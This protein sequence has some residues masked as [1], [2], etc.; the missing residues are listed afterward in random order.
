M[1]A[2]VMGGGL[3]RSASMQTAL[4]GLQS[5]IA[6]A[7]GVLIR[8]EAG[9]G[10]QEFARAVHLAVDGG[11]P[12]SVECLIEDAMRGRSSERPFIIVD[13]SA[14]A[15]LERDLFGITGTA[16]GQQFDALDRISDK[17]CL[18]AA[19]DG[20]IVFRHLTE[21]PARLQTRLA[22]ILRDGEALVETE[23]GD[24]VVRP[25]TT[26]PVATIELTADEDR[27]LPDLR[28]RLGRTTIDV[29]VLRNRREDIPA[30]VRFFLAQECAAHDLAPKKA[31]R[32]AIALLAALPWR[33]N[34]LELREL[35]RVLAL[36]TPTRLIRVSDVLAHVRL[37]GGPASFVSAGS[38]RQARERFEREYVASVLDQYH[39]RMADAARA[40]GIQRTNLYR[41][42]RQL[43]VGRRRGSTPGG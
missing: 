28:R 5:A 42:V 19:R 34:L 4:R 36:R 8:G 9:T 29:P 31:S 18:H 10:R 38:L 12:D 20:T 3:A 23:S 13:C 11:A 40:L 30:L 41:K 14:G 21:L 32:Q 7:G 24:T 25:I 43:A 27:L 22:R 6:T 2:A 26:R 1:T 16:V 17:S 35:L 39:G 15:G 37:D 33:G